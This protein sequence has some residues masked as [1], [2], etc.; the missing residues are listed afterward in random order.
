M[1]LPWVLCRTSPT[2][3][4]RTPR[5]GTTPALSCW[6]VLPGRLCSPFSASS[7]RRWPT[8]CGPMRPWVMTPKTCCWTP[9]QHRWPSASCTS[10]HRCLAPLLMCSD[11]KLARSGLKL[12]CCCS[13]SCTYDN[14]QGLRLPLGLE[15]PVMTPN[16]VIFFFLPEYLRLP[17]THMP[18][19]ESH[20]S[21]QNRVDLWLPSQKSAQA[22]Y[23][24]R[25]GSLCMHRYTQPVGICLVAGSVQ[26]PVGV[27]QAGVQPREASPGCHSPQGCSL[28]APVHLSGGGQHPVGAS[29]P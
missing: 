28:P 3:C 13:V 4:G 27:C 21:S 18:F 12:A 10:D 1:T 29:H 8:P 7:P 9:W 19:S 16:D 25:F 26:Q 22:P 14:R 6:M 2:P 5:C 20:C 17:V 23:A 15:A 24:M 11:S